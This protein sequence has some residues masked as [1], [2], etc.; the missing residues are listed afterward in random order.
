MKN[1]IIYTRFKKPNSVKQEQVKS[2]LF[3]FCKNNNLNVVATFEEIGHGKNFNRY[4]WKLVMNFLKN[5][6]ILIDCIVV[7]NYNHLSNDFHLTTKLIKK[8]KPLRI[9]VFS[10]EQT[11][12]YNDHIFKLYT[13]TGTGN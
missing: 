9:G 6:Y 11:F 10:T 2:E 4:K 3:Q 8:L 1:V 5:N 7:K 12:Q 13:K